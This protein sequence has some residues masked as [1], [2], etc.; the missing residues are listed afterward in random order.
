MSAQAAAPNITGN[1]KV[2][3][4]GYNGPSS[5]TL[6][7]QQSGDNIVG[8]SSSGNNFQ[9]KFVNDTQID[10]T[11]H[12]PGG[13]G[14]LT[15]Y[16][17]P[18]GHSFNGQWGYHGRGPNG[19]FVGNKFLPPSPITAK[20]TWNLTLAGGPELVSGTLTCTESGKAAVCHA[21][22]VTIDGRFRADDKIRATWKNSATGKT[23]WFSMWFNGDNNSFNGIWGYGAETTPPVGR[24]VGQRSLTQ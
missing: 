17:T 13:S 8:T 4:S 22:P 24:I 10:A 19:T 6:K 3:Q 18:N 14:W 23:G 15:V 12:G 11:W 7:L 1:W 2:E 5:T 21:G 16:V 20:G 9:G